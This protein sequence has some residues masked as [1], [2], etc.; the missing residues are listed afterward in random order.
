MKKLVRLLLV[1]SVLYGTG[2]HWALLQGGAWAGMLATRVQES[3]WAEAVASTFSGA[4][5]CRVCLVIDAGEK[6]QKAPEPLNASHNADFAVVSGPVL[7]V[8]VV[9]ERV[10]AAA[11]LARFVFASRPFG[12]PPKTVLPA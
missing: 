5:P 2:A 7:F 9:A 1:A 8:P 12:P 11:P 3:S 10:S 6:S 4:K